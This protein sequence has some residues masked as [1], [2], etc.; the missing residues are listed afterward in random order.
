VSDANV[1]PSEP[2]QPP[3][4]APPP[5]A[6]PPAYAPISA[7]GPVGQ[8]RNI[9]ISILLAIVTLGIYTLVWTYKTFDEMKRH[10]NAG[11]GGGIALVLQ[12]F[13]GVVTFF[14]APSEIKGLYDRAGQRTDLT[15]VWGLWFL[16]PI[17]GPFVWFIKVQ[18]ELNR[19]WVSKGATPV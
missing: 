11:V 6:P 12:I 1:P 8:P 3:P 15:P 2:T 5:A 13:V 19:Y 4:Y 18:G 10:S 9:G 16:L 17:I 7:T 14:L